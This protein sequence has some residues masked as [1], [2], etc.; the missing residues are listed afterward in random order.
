M[1]NRHACPHPADVRHEQ[2]GGRERHAKRLGPA[3]ETLCTSEKV[4]Y[5]VG[6]GTCTP[7]EACDREILGSRFAVNVPEF[8]YECLVKARV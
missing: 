6:N 5:V 1:A 4:D 8:T 7:E 3:D 2:A